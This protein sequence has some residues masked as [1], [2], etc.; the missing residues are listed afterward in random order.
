MRWLDY[1]YFHTRRYDKEFFPEDQ[2]Y[3]IFS[4]I[5]QFSPAVDDL[6]LWA[7]MAIHPPA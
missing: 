2:H 5:P 1:A 3:L 6:S 4:I 7:I